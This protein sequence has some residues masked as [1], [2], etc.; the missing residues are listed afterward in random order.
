VGV[1]KK[2]ADGSFSIC[3]SRTFKGAG[4]YIA[5]IS[6][7]TIDCL[8]AASTAAIG[9]VTNPNGNPVHS[10][11]FDRVTRFVVRYVKGLSLHTAAGV[12]YHK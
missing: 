4:G 7:E 5:S 9:I 10:E 11:M 8:F 3:T 2:N 1:I 12:G 6:V